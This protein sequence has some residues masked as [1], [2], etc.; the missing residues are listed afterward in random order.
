MG[1]FTVA[2]LIPV[3]QV[4]V[5]PVILVSGVGLLLLTMT[6]RLARVID[7]SRLLYREIRD[8]PS[9]DRASAVAQM[10]MLT[11]RARMIQRAITL[12]AVSVLLAAVLVIVLFLTAVFRWDDPWLIG[13]LFIGCMLSLI[14]SLLMFIRDL[15]RSLIALHMEVGPIEGSG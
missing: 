15:N 9:A 12:A 1:P 11:D 10:R 7:R 8:H 4:A 2:E 13:L 14:G 5:G 3:L 6:N